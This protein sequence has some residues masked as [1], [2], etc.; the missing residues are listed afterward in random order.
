MEVKEIVKEGSISGTYLVLDSQWRVARNG[1]P[2]A[3]LKIGDRSGEIALKVWE[4]T[5]P[6]FNQLQKGKV[7]RLEAVA[8]N[9]NGTLQLEANGR[10]PFF[11]ICP[12]DEYDPVVFLPGLSGS[13]L[14]KLWTVL[15]E[16]RSGLQQSAYRMLLEYFF[17]SEEF[18]RR[19]SSAPGAMRIHHAYRGGLLEHTV[20]VVTLCQTAAD[21]YPE[22]NRDL[23]LTGALLHDIGKLESY[24]GELTFEGTDQGK[25][26]GHLVLGVQMVEAAIAAIRADKG[27]GAFPPALQMPLI[28]LILSHH[29]ELEWGSPV[30]P[31]L[32]EACLLHHADH[33]D[34]EAAKFR[35]ALRQHPGG[36]NWTAYNRVLKRSVY[37]L[38]LE[39]EESGDQTN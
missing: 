4:I 6:V 16:T 17:G 25:L 22:V 37:L 27:E 28:H 11:Q 30:Q 13:H 9:F 38:D 2:F 20:G 36:G 26:I 29:G 12:E 32:L 31:A 1:S 15:D 8:K 19:F 23:L 14:E 24:T 3:A 10:E 33:M 21:L 7:I 35:E 5:E 34:A 18:R 39:A